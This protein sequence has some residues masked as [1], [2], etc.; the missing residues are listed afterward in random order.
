MG[1]EAIMAQFEVVSW[2]LPGELKK[3]TKTLVT[4]TNL[5]VEVQARNDIHS[6][7][8]SGAKC[9]IQGRCKLENVHGMQNYELNGM[10][11]LFYHIRY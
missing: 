5:Q 6:T 7:V 3:S 4:I 9:N 8:S 2:H 11:L 10:L 1:E